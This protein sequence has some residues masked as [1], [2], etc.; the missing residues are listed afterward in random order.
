ML[1]RSTERCRELQ[2]MIEA[3]EADNLL[4][5]QQS[6]E[7]MEALKAYE[8]GTD[9]LADKVQKILKLQETIAQ[10]DKQIHELVVEVNDQ[11]EIAAQNAI[12][13]RRLGIPDEEL[14]ETKGFL[15]KQKRFAKINDRLVLQLRASED[16]R[17]QLKIDKND[18]KRKINDLQAR[19]SGEVASNPESSVTSESSENP[20]IDAKQSKKEFR[21]CENC[22]ATYNVYESIKFCR[23]C[24]MRQHS[25]LCDNCTANVKV[26]SSENVELVRKIA[27]LEIDYQSVV[28]ENEKLREGLREIFGRMRGSEGKRCYKYWIVR[29]VGLP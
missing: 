27:K 28:D 29:E 26:T 1:E 24:I 20:Q 7:A 8:N 13:K 21:E 18:L 23:N 22:H 5:A 2:E 19:L 10:R 3:T 25:N 16:M 9:G 15:A 14:I 12:L 4:K 17:L 6:F 11:S